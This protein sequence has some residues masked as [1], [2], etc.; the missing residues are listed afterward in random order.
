VATR[1]LDGHARCDLVLGDRVVAE[2]SARLVVERAPFR[3]SGY[4]L[5]R[6]LRDELRVSPG[7]EVR[8]VRDRLLG[9]PSG[10]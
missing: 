5:S 9:V 1:A 8:A 6:L 10:A 3:E 7:P 4:A 2:R